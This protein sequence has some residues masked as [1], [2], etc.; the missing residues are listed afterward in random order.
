MEKRKFWKSV[1]L[2]ALIVFLTALFTLKIILI[3]FGFMTNHS[4]T[5]FLLLGILLIAF[6]ILILI[7]V[8]EHQA[9]AIRW[10]KRA[11]RF[12]D[13]EENKQEIDK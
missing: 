5:L 2:R 1:A 9:N 6:S 12:S 10:K 4:S 7:M 13:I 8:Y 3:S 11:L